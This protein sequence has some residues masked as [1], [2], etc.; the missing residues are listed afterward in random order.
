MRK[1]LTDQAV[2]VICILTGSAS[3]LLFLCELG[4]HYSG[5]GPLSGLFLSI[6]LMLYGWKRTEIQNILTQDQKRGGKGGT[7]IQFLLGGIAVCA[8]VITGVMIFG[9]PGLP[10]HETTVIIPGCGVNDDGTVS[11]IVRGRIDA[12]L[13]Y[14]QSHPDAKVIA[15]GGIMDASLLTEAE[16]IRNDLL[17]HGI[18]EDRIYV[19]KWSS[20][21]EENFRN[22]AQVIE[23]AKLSRNAVIASDGFHLYRCGHYARTFGLTPSALSART[24]WALLPGYYLREMAVIVKMWIQEGMS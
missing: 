8:A 7:M 4:L 20:T 15:S 21:T 1:I 11:L 22:S 6:C 12:A 13:P 19:E 2:R 16:S 3:A 17:E 9:R 14:L 5:I 24:P 10:D 23:E 18:A